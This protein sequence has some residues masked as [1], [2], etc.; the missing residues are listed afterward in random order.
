MIGGIEVFLPHRPAEVK[1]CVADVA[2]TE[3]QPT[4]TVTKEELEK[5]SE[6]PQLKEKKMCIRKNGPKISARS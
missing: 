5:T 3:G 4:E 6:I 1:N 2:T